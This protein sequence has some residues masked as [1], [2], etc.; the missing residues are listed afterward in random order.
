ML[1]AILSYLLVLETALRSN[2]VVW[3]ADLESNLPEGHS[4]SSLLS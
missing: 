4:A 3:K 2:P 1:E